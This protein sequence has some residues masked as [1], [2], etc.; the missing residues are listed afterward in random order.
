VPP[1]R[2]IW[3]SLALHGIG[4]T[5][6]DLFRF[7]NAPAGGVHEGCG[8][9]EPHAQCACAPLVSQE[10]F[11]LWI[12]APCLFFVANVGAGEREERAR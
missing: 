8:S 9:C 4:V 10:V 7:G 2:I 12:L 5:R 3:V 1:C 11:S 6:N